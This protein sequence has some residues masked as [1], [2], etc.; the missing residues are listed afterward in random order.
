MHIRPIV[1]AL[2]IAAMLAPTAVLAQ[3]LPQRDRPLTVTVRISTSYPLA[4]GDDEVAVQKQAREVFYKTAAGECAIITAALK[5]DCT[6]Q[7]LNINTGHRDIRVLGNQL[8]VPSVQTEATMS[9][10]VSPAAE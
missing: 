3:T 8:P 1:A 9:F 5:G 4:A 7:R 2:G 10:I 6:L